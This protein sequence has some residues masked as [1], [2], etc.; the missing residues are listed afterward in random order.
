MI[1]LCTGRSS[2]RDA[3]AAAEE[4]I[5][6]ALRGAKNAVFALVL[7][8]DQYDSAALAAAVS[9]RLG[10]IP[11]AGC[12][13]AGVFTSEG[14][15]L[16]GLV[17]GVL[18]SSDL[19]VGLGVAGPLSQ[20]PK[21]AGQVAMSQ[22]LRRLDAAGPA[23][24]RAY[25][26][27]PDALTCN[28]AEVV[29]GA[30][31]EAGTIGSWSGGGA[32]DNLRFIRTAQFADGRAWNDHVVIAALDSPRPMGNGVAHGWAAHGKSV[33][34][35]MSRESVAVQLDYQKAVCVY[36]ALARERGYELTRETFGAF[37]MLHPLG[38]AQADGGYIIRDPLEVEN[39]GGLSFAGEMPQ[40]SFVKLMEGNQER[41][42]DAAESAAR[43]ARK[44]VKGALGG[45]IIFDCVSRSLLI[46]NGMHQELARFQAALGARVP[47]IG[48]LA[49]GEVG[50][51]PAQMPQF[52][53][54]TSV[55]L[56][57]PGRSASPALK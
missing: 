15:L 6:A 57:L 2:H 39:D 21:R 56:A 23:R 26:V 36:Q 27:M 50:A 5:G 37:A 19:R 53:N 22:A 24:H 46:K 25:I 17:V 13:T 10:A 11:W 55:V 7:S 47:L 18:S 32:G 52:H 9:R 33:M 40:G 29:R 1:K 3:E 20:N 31:Q 12:C 45:A 28:A 54:K 51:P 41:L 8:T 14:L 48:C 34:V 30:A 42:L 35:T 4:A 49:F 43:G 38:I 44:A 16:Q